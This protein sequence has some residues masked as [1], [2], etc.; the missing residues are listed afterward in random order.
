LHPEKARPASPAGPTQ[1][2]REAQSAADKAKYATELVAKQKADAKA[3]KKKGMVSV[4]VRGSPSL[5]DV[6]TRKLD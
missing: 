2:Q 4:I 6:P 5:G 1:K 3:N